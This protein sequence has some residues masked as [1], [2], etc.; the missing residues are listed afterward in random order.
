M[1]TANLRRRGDADPIRIPSMYFQFL[2]F[3]DFQ[4][5]NSRYKD[6]TT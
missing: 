4:G 3:W 5:Q 1:P 2:N 6:G